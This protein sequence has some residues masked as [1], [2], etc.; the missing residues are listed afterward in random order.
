MPVVEKADEDDDTPAE[1]PLELEPVAAHEADPND[2]A[3][4]DEEPHARRAKLVLRLFSFAL[5]GLR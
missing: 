2:E 5:L 4:L 3:A 1:E